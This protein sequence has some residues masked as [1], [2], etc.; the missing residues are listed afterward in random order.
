MGKEVVFHLQQ[1]YRTKKYTTAWVIEEVLPTAILTLQ[2]AAV[3]GHAVQPHRRT[4]CRPTAIATA[5]Q[6]GCCRRRG[7]HG[8]PNAVLLAEIKKSG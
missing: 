6:T 5:I 7:G 4:C 3:Q 8:G 2:L 1:T